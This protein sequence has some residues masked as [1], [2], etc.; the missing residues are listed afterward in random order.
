MDAAAADSTNINVDS[1]PVHIID[2][3]LRLP[4]IAVKITGNF[5]TRSSVILRE[6]PVAIGDTLTDE[7]VE[8]SQQRVYNIGLFNS[9]NVTILDDTIRGGAI[10]YIIVSERWYVFPQFVLGVRDRAWTGIFSKGS[11]LYAGLGGVD[12]N[13]LGLN[14]KLYA[15]FAAGYDPWVDAEWDKIALDKS[16]T[17]LLDIS[18]N[19]S[20]TVNE[21]DTTYTHGEAFNELSYDVSALLHYR[22]TQQSYFFCRCRVS[23][24]PS[25]Q[26]QRWAYIESI[27]QR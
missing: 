9:V 11:K 20:S 10:M 6:L 13:F 26:Q 12:Y 17:F 8:K 4:L 19:F 21:S 27:G 14:E 2:S 23:G 18:T 22:A 5:R 25:L 24:S 7:L 1:L 15:A 3:S 16:Q